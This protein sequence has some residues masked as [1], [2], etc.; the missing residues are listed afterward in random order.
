MGRVVLCTE[1]TKRAC[2]QVQSDRI[3]FRSL[4]RIVVKGRAE[5]VELFEPM[6]L[7]EDTTDALR[8]CVSEFERGLVRFQQSDWAGAIAHFA[9]S[10]A[11]EP[12]QVGR[13][14]GITTNPSLLFTQLAQSFQANPGS[15]PLV[16]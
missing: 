12:N 10:G 4:G 8:E 7:R 1:A 3:L 6:A 5:P 13:D 16:V 9:K 14:P 15:N 11:M 2:G